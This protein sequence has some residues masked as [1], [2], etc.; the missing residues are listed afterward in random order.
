[1]SST[2][3]DVGQRKTKLNLQC[4]PSVSRLAMRAITP[5]MLMQG[6]LMGWHMKSLSLVIS[7]CPHFI[8]LRH[9]GNNDI[10]WQ[11]G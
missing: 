1:M 8:S 4:R 10:R 9:E 6:D 5:T 3:E 2:K 7:C 11:F